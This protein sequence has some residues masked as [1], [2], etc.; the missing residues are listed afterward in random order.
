MHKLLTLFP[1]RKR[2]V[3]GKVVNNFDEHLAFALNVPWSHG[4]SH[5]RRVRMWSS[6]C[7]LSTT[8]SILK[9]QANMYFP[10]VKRVPCL[11]FHL[12]QV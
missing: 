9:K 1:V 12:S 10:A 8:C 4:V 3:L 7:N 11:H 2:L 6:V 5:G